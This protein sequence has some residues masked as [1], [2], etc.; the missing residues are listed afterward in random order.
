MY[1]GHSTGNAALTTVDTNSREGGEQTIIKV[2]E[3]GGTAITLAQKLKCDVSRH[4]YIRVQSSGTKWF[5]S[6]GGR[7]KIPERTQQRGLVNTLSG[8]KPE[9][10]HIVRG[11]T[12]QVAVSPCS[13]YFNYTA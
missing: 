11:T 13:N 12:V 10:L 2:G 1:C 4:Q 3:A 9:H 5:A 7:K 8:Y 6:R